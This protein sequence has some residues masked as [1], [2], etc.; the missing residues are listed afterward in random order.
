MAH[1]LWVFKEISGR[2]LAPQVY[3]YTN[4]MPVL[5]ICLGCAIVCECSAGRGAPKSSTCKQHIASQDYRGLR[6]AGD[7]LKTRLII[8]QNKWTF[9]TQRSFTTTYFHTVASA[10]ILHFKWQNQTVSKLV[11]KLIHQLCVLIVINMRHIK[12]GFA[13]LLF[14]VTKER[15]RKKGSLI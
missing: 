5:V 6:A 4:Q 13:S 15:E 12:R 1:C 7:S 10:I 9:M 11:S 2:Q 8:W 3:H 14:S